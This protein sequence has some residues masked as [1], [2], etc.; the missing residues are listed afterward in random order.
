METSLSRNISK[1][2]SLADM[3]TRRFFKGQAINMIH[4]LFLLEILLEKI[5]INFVR[6]YHQE[7][8]PEIDSLPL[9]K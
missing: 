3:S 8:S 1:L 9:E 7:M 6:N 2:N 5:N 4:T